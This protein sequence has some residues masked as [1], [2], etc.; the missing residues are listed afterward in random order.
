MSK[1]QNWLS[2][3][4]KNSEL[5]TLMGLEFFQDDSERAYLKKL[6]IDTCINFLAR[7]ISQAEFRIMDGDNLD[8]GD[9]YYK[10][11]IRPNTDQSSTD[12]WQYFV[13]KLL[14]DNEVLVILTDTD[15][16][17][18]ADS[19]VRNE[20]ALYDD[21]FESVTVKNYTFKRKFSMDEVI[22]LKYNNE[23]LE[24]YISGLFGDYGE[25]FGRML[26]VSLRNY[27]IRGTVGVGQL[28]GSDDEKQKKLQG[29]IDKMFQAFKKPIA[30][31]PITKGFD[32]SELSSK[33][34]ETNQSF[35][36]LGKLKSAMISEVAK[37]IGIPPALVHGE[38]ADLEQNMTSYIDFCV[39]PLQKK[40]EDE[41]NAK[42]FEIQEFRAGKHVD[43]SGIDK[44]DPVKDAEKIDKLIS[45]G[46]MNINGVRKEY[47]LEPREGGDVY[48]MTKNYSTELEGGENVDEDGN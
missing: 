16:L 5:E 1:F 13:Y 26:E 27:Q 4:K 40:I 25:L 48:V 22:Y 47:G 28:Q 15:D 33:S 35:E 19:W 29:F 6:S 45:S 37:L 12:F 41:L 38:M 39:K 24:N 43:I 3:Y 46:F 23:A 42:L 36:E 31:V 17:L 10:L 34:G 20:Y 14:F 44:P 7:T 30:L 18:I 9:W 11:N 8:K 32:Y 2:I 21:T